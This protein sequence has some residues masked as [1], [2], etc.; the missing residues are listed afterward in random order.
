MTGSTEQPK[1]ARNFSLF[2]G[3]FVNRAFGMIA[4]GQQKVRH[5]AGRCLV[6]IVL[7]WLPTAVLAAIG[8]NY[9]LDVNPANFFADYAAYAQFL[10]GLPLFVIAEAIV[11][12]ATFVKK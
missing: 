8:G 9:S 10:L 7:T 2:E 4:L 3:D 11:S 12:R 1:T 6:L 5:V